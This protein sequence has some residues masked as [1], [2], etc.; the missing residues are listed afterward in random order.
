MTLI[1]DHPYV[2]E[3]QIARARIEWI[4]CRINQ[5]SLRRRPWS[6]HPFSASDFSFEESKAKYCGHGN[7][8]EYEDQQNHRVDEIDVQPIERDRDHPFEADPVEQRQGPRYFRMPWPPEPVRGPR[9][10]RVLRCFTMIDILHVQRLS[11]RDDSTTSIGVET[12]KRA[13]VRGEPATNPANRKSRPSSPSSLPRRLSL[14]SRIGLHIA[15]EE[16][17]V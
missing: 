1:L 16:L 12:A 7:G 3:M 10:R 15:S 11:K 6:Y 2:P 13:S 17:A 4:R 14:R 8:I 9:R 5:R